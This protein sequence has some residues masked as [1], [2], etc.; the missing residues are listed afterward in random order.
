MTVNAILTGSRAYGVPTA[1]SDTDVVMLVDQTTMAVLVG[2]A[3]EAPE[4]SRSGTP[5]AAASV[6]F[7]KLNLILHTE[8]EIFDAWRAATA[9]LIARKPVERD[10]AV[11]VIK[12]H[13]A[14]AKEGA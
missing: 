5:G 8:P 4:A 10:E 12:S 13:M 6:R 1:T 14:R 7:G 11:K 3:D 2:E 9:E